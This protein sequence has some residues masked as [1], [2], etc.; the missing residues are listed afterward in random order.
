MLIGQTISLI[1]GMFNLVLWG[2]IAIPQ[3]YQNY[4]NSSSKALSYLLFYKLFIGGIISLSIALIKKTS[5][6]IIYIG[7]HHLIITTILLTQLLYYR[8]TNSY[9]LLSNENDES[10]K[11][12]NNE[13]Y[14]DYEDGIKV[15]E[16]KPEIN[17]GL[18]T[19]EKLITLIVTPIICVLLG[20]VIITRNVLLIEI[21]AWT[22]NILFTTSKFTQIYINYKTKSTTGLSKISFVCMIFTDLCFMISVLSNIIDHPASEIILKNIQWLSSCT[23]SLVSGTIIL[24]QFHLYRNARNIN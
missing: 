9:I 17:I 15:N 19:T 3:I 16:S 18:T 6:T 5:T 8:F 22:A 7:I 10:Y 14:E 4:K 21:L 23:I 13:D 20:T 2:G 1:F 12:T 11:S 24:V